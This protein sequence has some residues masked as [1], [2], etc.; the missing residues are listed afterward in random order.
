MAVRG[1]PRSEKTYET[2]RNRMSRDG[3]LSRLV[4]ERN[5]LNAICVID[6]NCESYRV[7]MPVSVI[8]IIFP[9][10]LVAVDF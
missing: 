8:S 9:N 10:A 5:G 4:V 2:G 3:W 6:R 1:I 7:F